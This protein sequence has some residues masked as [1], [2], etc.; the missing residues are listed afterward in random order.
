M[1]SAEF[2]VFQTLRPFLRAGA[3]HLGQAVKLAPLRAFADLEKV[4]K[5]RNDSTTR[6]DTIPIIT[7]RSP[8]AAELEK[9]KLCATR[10]ENVRGSGIPVETERPGTP[11]KIPICFDRKA[12]ILPFEVFP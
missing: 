4:G 5:R 7:P 12:G 6:G 1:G 2:G 11:I 9:P 3:N 10:F 8:K